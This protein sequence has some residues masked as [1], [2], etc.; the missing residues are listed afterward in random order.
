MKHSGLILRSG[1]T[2]FAAACLIF[3]ASVTAQGQTASHTREPQRNFAPAGSFSLSDFESINTTNGN[4]ILRYSLGQLPPGRNAMR[5]GFHLQYNSKL[6]DT[7]I[8][9]AMDTSGQGS[10]QNLLK[11]SSEGGWKL[12]FRYELLITNRNSEI[13]GG[14]E[15][16]A[17]TACQQTVGN[18]SVENALATYNWKVKMRFPDGTEHVFRPSGY[19]DGR[20]DGYFNVDTFGNVRTYGCVWA[21]QSMGCGCASTQSTDP[22]PRMTYYSADGSY[23]RLTIER[24]QTW[25]L[26]YPDG[27]KVAQEVIIVDGNEV[28]VQKVYDRNGAFYT[29]ASNT[30]SDNT[31]RSTTF[32][33][34]SNTGDY[35]ITQN[36]VEN[37]PLVWRIKWKTISIV[38][39]AY[40]STP[41]SSGQL[42]GNSAVQQ[43]T[44]NYSVVDKIILPEQLGGLSYTFN[45][46]TS[47]EWAE[48]SSITLPAA[49]SETPPQVTYQYSYPGGSVNQLLKSTSILRSHVFTKTL[50][51]QSQNGGVTTPVVETWSYDIGDTV[52]NITEPDGGVMTQLHGETSSPKNDSGLVKRIVRPDGSK[53]ERIWGLN[54]QPWLGSLPPPMTERNSVID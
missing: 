9:L 38:N 35:L 51:W 5:G 54:P 23:L 43:W 32:T 46:N 42:Q 44:N 27:S 3:F 24:N 2:L 34:D 14:Y 15:P 29:I 6:Y 18:S 17:F 25:T 37:V 40:S 16:V 28:P 36:G 22:N 12:H 7:V 1:I 26:Y 19:A 52:S 45:Y 50:V 20:G 49:T 13:E 33:V 10:M 4:L 30:I 31:G 8:G 39:R 53:T 21:P 11:E 47:S 41:A 48:V